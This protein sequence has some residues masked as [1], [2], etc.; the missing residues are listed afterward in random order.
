MFRL[1][2]HRQGPRVHVLGVRIHEW[3][4]GLAIVAAL[5]AARIWLTDR[6]GGLR[7]GL[8]SAIAEDLV[9]QYLANL[10]ASLGTS[11]NEAAL[12]QVIGGGN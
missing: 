9:T 8:A 5:L 7:A 4:L 3:Q 12:N 1:E 10:Q 6:A 11:I 2:R